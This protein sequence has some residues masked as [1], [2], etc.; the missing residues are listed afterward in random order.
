[1]HVPAQQAE[2]CMIVSDI[3]VDQNFPPNPPPPERRQHSRHAVDDTATILLVKVASRIEGRLIDLS[4]GGCRIRCAKPFPVGIYTR[5]EVEFRVEGLSFRLGG[6]VQAIHNRDTVG[7]RFLDVS[8]RK[9]DQ[10][11]QLMDELKVSHERECCA[12]A[13]GPAPD[14]AGPSEEHPGGSSGFAT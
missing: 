3:R 8:Q 10:L 9:S 7:I 14:S 2:Q 5:V 12:K 4:L 6:V 13:E 1:M 11:T